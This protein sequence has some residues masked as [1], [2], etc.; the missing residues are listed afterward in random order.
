VHAM[1]DALNRRLD[2]PAAYRM[3]PWAALAV[4]DGR[5]NQWSGC[6]LPLRSRTARH[7]QVWGRIVC[8]KESKGDGASCQQ[9]NL[10]RC[11][12]HAVPPPT[13]GCQPAPIA[14]STYRSKWPYLWQTMAS[15]IRTRGPN[16]VATHASSSISQ[17]L[18]FHVLNSLHRNNRLPV[19]WAFCTLKKKVKQTEM[20]FPRDWLRI[21][22]P[23]QEHVNECWEVSSADRST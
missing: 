19:Q 3:F 6:L 23:G 8:V 17:Q 18:L 11:Q 5:C 10:H 7:R 20:I 16:S 4:R 21:A 1:L 13:C 12:S 14:I 22:G 9:D 15:G 2:R